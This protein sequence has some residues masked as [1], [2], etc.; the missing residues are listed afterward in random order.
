MVSAAIVLIVVTNYLVLHSVG[1]P[2]ASAS[3]LF[4]LLLPMAFPS[5]IAVILVMSSLYHA[6]Q[7]VI[8]EL[9]RSRQDAVTQ[10]QHDPLTGDCCRSGSIKQSLGFAEAEKALRY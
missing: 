9:D 2:G 6:L 4:S 10:A 3:E 8:V 1:R 5:T 7:E